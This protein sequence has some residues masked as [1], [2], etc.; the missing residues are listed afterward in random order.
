VAIISDPQLRYPHSVAFTPCNQLIVTNA[1]ANYFSHFNSRKGLWNLRW[2][3]FA[4]LQKTVNDEDVFRE[5]NAGNKME[6]GPKGIAT[7]GNTIAECSPELGINLYY[8]RE[9]AA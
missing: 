4:S 2:S 7:H 6:G 5:V 3:E 8:F 9:F 1:G